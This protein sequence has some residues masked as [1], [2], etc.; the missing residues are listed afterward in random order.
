MKTQFKKPLA[1][2]ACA[3]A[4]WLVA[5]CG[6]SSGGTAASTSL[7]GA[8]IDGYIEGATV[9]LDLNANLACDS[10]EP[11]ATTAKDGSYKLDTSALTAEQ[12]K[13]AHLLTVVLESAKDADDG[14]KTLKEAGKKG[15]MMQAPAAAYASSSSAISGAVISPLT[16]MVS[17]DMIT[18]GTP[19]ATAQTVV[20]QR[21]SLAEGTDLGQDYVAKKDDKLLAQA[22]MLAVALSEVKAQA[23]AT[24][25]TTVPQAYLAALSYLQTQVSELQKAFD[26][27]KAAN[28][29]A[30]PVDL[31]KT[32]LTNDAAKPVVANLLA[33]AKKTTDS[34]PVASSTLT[35]MLEEGFYGAEHIL[36]DCANN[37][38]TPNYWKI[39][40]SAG[41]ITTDNDYKLS[42]GSWTKVANN[43][44]YD[45][46]LSTKGWVSENKCEAG[47]SASYAVGADGVTTVTFCN[48]ATERV[49]TRSVDAAGKTL[50]ALGVNPPTAYAST[51]MPAGSKLYWFEFANTEDRYNLYAGNPVQTWN[52]SEQKNLTFASLDDFLSTFTT[53]SQATVT[54]SLFLQWSGLRFSFDAA[55]RSDT[56]G[57]LTLWDSSAKAI[58]QSSYSIRT[59]Q[60]QKVLVID[61]QAPDKE[62]GRRI[63]F[64]V[65]DNKVYGGDLRPASVKHE[66]SPNFNKTMI[67]ALLAAA[68]RPSVVD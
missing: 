38:C 59:V 22:Q 15:F 56:G 39:Q 45:L 37:S 61:E 12:I 67:N 29:T 5:A 48:G 6:G 30:K 13:A 43:G 64:A 28:A 54:D 11:S 52:S 26:T 49:T 68:K 53:P 21:L 47:Q 46:I 16:T 27:A 42:N 3:M 23:M 66:S 44:D 41:K 62:R 65:Y 8:V 19:L 17:H 2:T 20:R 31:V 32:A 4:T 9:C 58:G 55:G 33:N 57:K 50:S 25:N 14:G 24:T 40:G 7:S 63:F 36:E 34:T 60:G 35:A 1:L 18:S 51:V 10:N